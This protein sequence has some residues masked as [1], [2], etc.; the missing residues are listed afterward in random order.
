MQLKLGRS[1]VPLLNV[2]YKIAAIML[3]YFDSLKI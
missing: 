3:Q 2:R 1:E